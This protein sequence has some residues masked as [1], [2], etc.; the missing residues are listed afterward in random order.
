VADTGAKPN[1][2]SLEGAQAITGILCRACFGTVTRG[3]ITCTVTIAGIVTPVALYT[4]FTEGDSGWVQNLGPEYPTVLIA[5]GSGGINPGVPTEDNPETNGAIAH[6]QQFDVNIAL[7]QANSDVDYEEWLPKGDVFIYSGHA[8]AN[9]LLI[10][11][12]LTGF[13]E[14]DVMFAVGATNNTN[15]L[16]RQEIDQYRAGKQYT[17]VLL[18]ACAGA[19]PSSY[20]NFGG[21]DQYCNNWAAAFGTQNLVTYPGLVRIAIAGGFEQEYWNQRLLYWQQHETDPDWYSN[22]VTAWNAWVNDL[23]SKYALDALYEIPSG[24]LIRPYKYPG[25]LPTHQ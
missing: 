24:N 6:W 18:S 17:F 15:Q 7:I 1:I 14:E 2:L 23:S 3:F 22:M 8:N 16:T 4:Y 9:Y 11:R 12:D 10:N 5:T 13:T 20:N 19:G 25:P 21:G